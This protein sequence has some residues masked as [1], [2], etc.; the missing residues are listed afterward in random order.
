MWA[1]D[2]AEKTWAYYFPQAGINYTAGITL[3]F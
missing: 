3:S 2:G 1:E